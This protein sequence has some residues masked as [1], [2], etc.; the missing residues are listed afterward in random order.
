MEDIGQQLLQEF[1]MKIKEQEKEDE[2]TL[3]SF[4]LKSSNININTQDIHG[5]TPLIIACKLG[6]EEVVCSLLCCPN[7]DMNIADK[8]GNTALLNA[9]AYGYEDIVEMLLDHKDIQVNKGDVYMDTPLM[10]AINSYSQHF[11]VVKLLI[12][13]DDINVNA[14]NNSGYTALMKSLIDIDIADTEIIRS[15]LDHKDIDINHTLPQ[16]YGYMNALTLACDIGHTEAISMLLQREEI[17]TTTSNIQA[18]VDFVMNHLS[19]ES[20]V[21][22]MC[23]DIADARDMRTII[24]EAVSKNLT[25]IARWLVKTQG[26]LFSA[27]TATS[28]LNGSKRRCIN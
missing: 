8:Y 11:G 27:C 15:L 19:G 22:N 21:Q 17:Q 7:L 1:W 14:L 10:M 26:F 25:D 23:I 24:E 2:R 3:E 12:N 4:L 5:Q 28:A 20:F 13:R 16:E 9:S 6:R 18:V